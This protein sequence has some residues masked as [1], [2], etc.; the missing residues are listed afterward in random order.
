[1]ISCNANPLTSYLD[2][3]NRLTEFYDNYM[4]SYSV[5][6]NQPLPY[7]RSAGSQGAT[8]P[9]RLAVR[10]PNLSHSLSRSGPRSA[11]AS[12]HSSF[13]SSVG[14]IRRRGTTRANART[15]GSIK[16]TYEDEEGYASGDYDDT[17]FD[18]AKIRV[19]VNIKSTAAVQAITD[20]A[21]QVHYQDDVRGMTLTSDTP[22]EEFVEKITSKFG[23]PFDGLSLKFMYEDGGKVTLR[24]ESDYELAIETARESSQGK[25]EGKLEIWCA[26][27]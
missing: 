23:R 1:M 7:L 17:L 16:S 19:K 4:D 13:G 8:S 5:D 6:P 2:P 14:S 26:D 18:L 3:N 12:N 22:F 27:R 25:G 9:N 20:M 15:P 24:D 11:P 21:V 10:G